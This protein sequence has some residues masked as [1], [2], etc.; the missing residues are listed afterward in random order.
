MPITTN[1]DE[2]V[3]QLIQSQHHDT[4]SILADGADQAALTTAINALAAQSATILHATQATELLH[5]SIDTLRRIP[6]DELPTY[7]GVGRAALYMRK[8]IEDYVR[9][10]KK[11][12]KRGTGRGCLKESAAPTPFVEDLNPADL[13][14]KAMKGA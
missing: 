8:D 4:R 5:C 2:F 14:L 9:G 10:R 1:P 12:A 3:R 6:I 7:E 13:A 11:V